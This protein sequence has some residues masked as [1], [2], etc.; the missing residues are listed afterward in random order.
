M[1]LIYSFPRW[2]QVLIALF[3]KKLASPDAR[4]RA[5]V[6]T[7]RRA[8][9]AR[10]NNGKAATMASLTQAAPAPRP[11]Y[12]AVAQI[13]RLTKPDPITP[14][15]MARALDRALVIALAD[16]ELPALWESRSSR[17]DRLDHQL[18]LQIKDRLR[19]AHIRVSTTDAGDLIVE[20]CRGHLTVSAYRKVPL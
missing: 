6:T 20:L 2:R 14:E 11:V 17:H 5:T 1:L 12:E 13:M 19:R 10:P 3:E 7:I 4:R 18:W 8:L 9:T 16:P 15:H